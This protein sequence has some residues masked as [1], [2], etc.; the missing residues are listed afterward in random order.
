[1]KLEPMTVEG[2]DGL[3]AIVHRPTMR[4][5]KHLTSATPP[6]IYATLRRFTRCS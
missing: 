3:K 6:G 1:M 2:F 4:S 5:R